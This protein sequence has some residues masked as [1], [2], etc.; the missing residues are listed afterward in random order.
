MSNMVQVD[1]KVA[2]VRYS[3]KVVSGQ[4]SAKMLINYAQGPN[5]M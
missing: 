2:V 1:E 4:G 3:K 5:K